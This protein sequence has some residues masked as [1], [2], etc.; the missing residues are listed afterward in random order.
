MAAQDLGCARSRRPTWPGR[1]DPALTG[2]ILA[3][4][5]NLI[6]ARPSSISPHDRTRDVIEG[7]DRGAR[8]RFRPFATVIRS[9][10]TETGWR[11]ADNVAIPSQG[12]DMARPRTPQPPTH[13]VSARMLDVDRRDGWSSR[14]TSSSTMGASSQSR[15]SSVPAE[16]VAIDLGDATLLPG[17]MDMEVNLLM[18]G[19]NHAS[20]AGPGAG[21]PRPED[22]AGR[23]QRSPDPPRRIHHRAQSRAV[24]PDRRSPARRGPDEGHRHG[25]V[26]RTADRPG[27]ACHQPRPGAI[28]T[29]PCSRPSP[30]TSCPSPWRRGSPTG[31]PRCARPSA[32]R[33]STGPR[34]SR[35]AHRAG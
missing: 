32:T 15:P 33:S 7:R 19:P 30:P 13:L 34:S 35:S 3:P 5:E 23:R 6:L 22:A 27:R 12:A 28:S 1:T 26:R 20:P 8:S 24:R 21:G 4:D 2:G 17:L 25:L 29:P 31:S 9:R 14:A 11:W 16:A 18:G 10:P